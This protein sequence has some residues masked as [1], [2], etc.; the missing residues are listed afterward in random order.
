MPFAEFLAWRARTGGADPELMGELR[1][2]L[3]DTTDDV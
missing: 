3:T 1:A 2:T